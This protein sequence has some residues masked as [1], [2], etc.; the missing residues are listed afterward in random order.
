MTAAQQRQLSDLGKDYVKDL[1]G[2]AVDTVRVFKGKNRVDCLSFRV[3]QSKSIIDEIDRVLARH[4]GFTAEELD[5]ILNYDIK[6]RLGRDP[7]EDE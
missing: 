6:Y 1:K 2:N 5:F 3:N 4:Y 7:G